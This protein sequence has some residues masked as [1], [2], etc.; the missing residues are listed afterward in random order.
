MSSNDYTALTAIERARLAYEQMKRR[1]YNAAVQRRA[2]D[3]S[4]NIKLAVTLRAS[5]LCCFLGIAIYNGWLPNSL[6]S[7]AH[8]TRARR[9][10]KVRRNANRARSAASSRATPARRL[11]FN[12]D[13]GI[14]VGGSPGAV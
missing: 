1:Q 7:S 13:M 8:A 14:Y 6:R 5:R 10:Q 11:Q 2:R 12:N 9:R 3:R 4:R